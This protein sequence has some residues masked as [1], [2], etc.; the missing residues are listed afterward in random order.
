MITFNGDKKYIRGLSN[1]IRELVKQIAKDHQYTIKHIDY[2][3]V[4][5]EELLE[6]NRQS[7]DHDF[8]TDIISFDYTEGDVI[9]GEIYISIDRVKD[10]AKQFKE[11]FHVEL[12]R[13]LFH[14]VLHYVGYKD[15]TPKQ[16]KIMREK[17]Q[18]YITVFNN[19][20][21]VEQ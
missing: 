20:F 3:F 19:R 1:Q 14:G 7:L 18:H 16:K 10:N 9:E 15:K 21:H 8:Y 12:L 2:N 17:E 13:V 6:I 11:K 4:G 5:D